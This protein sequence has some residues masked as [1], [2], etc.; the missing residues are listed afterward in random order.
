MSAVQSI[1]KPTGLFPQKSGTDFCFTVYGD[2][3]F[4]VSQA[5]NAGV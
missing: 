5:A 3:D 4:S 1:T 2:S